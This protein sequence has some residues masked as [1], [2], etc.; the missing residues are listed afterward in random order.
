MTMKYL[1]TMIRV[2]DLEAALDFFVGKFGLVETRR[3]NSEKGR[4]TLV[5]LAAA[6]DAET[7]KKTQAPLLELTYN[8]DPE[9]YTRRAQFRPSR[10]CRRRHLRDLRQAAK[11][12]GR[13]QPPAARRPHGVHPHPRRDLD[14]VAAEGRGAARPPSPG[15]RWPIPGCGEV[16]GR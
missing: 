2:S 13:H 8:W 1:H 14:R 3:V 11:G 7:A 15:R 5:F 10:L 12:G 16:R 9:V 6:D 4:Y